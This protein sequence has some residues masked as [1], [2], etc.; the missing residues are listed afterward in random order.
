[1]KD[2]KLFKKAR[3]QKV[4]QNIL[5]HLW[6]IILLLVFLICFIKQFPCNY[7]LLFTPGYVVPK[8]IVSNSDGRF[9]ESCMKFIEE[10]DPNKVIN[11]V[12][13]SNPKEV[14]AYLEKMERFEKT[15]ESKPFPAMKQID[16]IL[17]VS[18]EGK[19]RILVL[20]SEDEV[21]FYR[22]L[23]L[24]DTEMNLLNRI[25]FNSEYVQYF[26][27]AH[28]TDRL[29]IQIGSSGIMGFLYMNEVFL[30]NDKIEI[31]SLGY[32]ADGEYHTYKIINHNT[33][34][35]MFLY[36]KGYILLSY[37]IILLILF[38]VLILVLGLFLMSRNR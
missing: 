7:L 25:E 19:D 28:F 18:S 6:L 30:V 12:D 26:L 23:Y 32:G 22:N 9:Y 2:N 4:F 5:K 27:S 1:M 29:W 16:R 38:N 24:F 8:G 33:N 15:Y 11:A 31:K 14:N 17:P 35:Q 21:G 34:P 20:G 10:P 13:S 3:N 36:R 37:L